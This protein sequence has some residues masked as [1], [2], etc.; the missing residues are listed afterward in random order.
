MEEYLQYLSILKR[1]WLP[2]S[3][4]FLAVLAL[5]IVKMITETPLYQ[6]TG[7][8]SLKK[9]S[10]SSLTGVEASKEIG[11][12]DKRIETEAA[13]LRSLPLVENTIN[14]LNLN[15]KPK[16]LL[17]GLNVK[18][19][20]GTDIL[21]IYYTSPDPEEAASIVNTLMKTYIQNDIKAN[22]AQTKSAREFI[23]QQLPPTKAELQ[24]AERKLQYFKQENGALD[25]K[26][27]STSIVEIIN[28]LQKEAD[29]TRS[30]LSSFKGRIQSIQKLFGVTSFDATMSNFVSESPAI[31]SALAKLQEVQEKIR[32]LGL[33]LTDEHPRIIDLKGEEAILKQELKQ[34]VKQ[35]FVGQA[36]RLNQKTK[37]EEIVQL[38]DGGLQEQLLGKYANSQAEL[39]SLQLRLK[40]LK[41]AIQFYKERANALPK[42]ELQQRQIDREITATGTSYQ[43]LLARYQELQVAENLQI[44]DARIIAP[45]S[46]PD[47]SLKNR[48]NITLIQG[49]FGGLVLAAGTAFILERL[50]NTIKTPES[51]QAL[52]GYNLLGYI[53]PFPSESVIPEVIVKNQ[54]D[55]PISEAFRMMETNLRVF[56]SE[57]S[58]KVVVVS[59]A[60]PGEGKSTVAANLAFSISHLG[61]RV[62]LVDAD[63]RSPSQQK[64][65]QIPNE[66]GLSDFLQNQLDLEQIVHEVEPN[67]EIVTAGKPNSNPGAMLNSSQ[68]AIFVAQVAQK[69]DFVIIDTP[70]LTVAADATILGKLVNGIVFVVRP[71]VSQTSSITL[72]KEM[73]EKAA[74]NV[75]GV[76]MNGTNAYGQYYYYN[77]NYST[78]SK[79]K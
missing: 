16:N 30:E 21:E 46:I 79:S 50:D 67:L 78:K 54:P 12:N 68:M 71:G 36:G 40:S 49:I 51:A 33:Q 42:L 60:V 44:S 65:W 55:S 31:K 23:A 8:M 69:Y 56:N 9:N 63:L 57:Q 74:Q 43:S 61:S 58:I 27:E 22:R 32:I 53:P 48:R 14:A 3:V 34:R 72:A 28:S 26:A 66:I 24:K 4:V 15:I 25:L 2:C 45:A 20:E 59:S 70:P 11:G 19:L 73:L 52:L 38:K 18:I 41:E 64:I 75:L 10:A 47:E 39:F 37:P 76:V 5:S 6:A 77:Y 13:I 7:Q 17:T 62:L 29:Q 35:S 1:R